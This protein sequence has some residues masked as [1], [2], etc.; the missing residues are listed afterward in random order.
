MEKNTLDAIKEME[1]KSIE[2]LKLLGVKYAHSYAGFREI[3]LQMNKHFYALC[4]NTIRK[5]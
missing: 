1:D 2:E 3:L 4:R 5:Q